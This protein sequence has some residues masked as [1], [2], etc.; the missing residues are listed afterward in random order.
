MKYK[1]AIFQMRKCASVTEKNDNT[2]KFCEHNTQLEGYYGQ[3]GALDGILKPYQRV[4]WG[5]KAVWAYE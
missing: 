2:L 4:N 1:L 5:N 3:I